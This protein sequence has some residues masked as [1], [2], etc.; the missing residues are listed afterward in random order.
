[1][2]RPLSIRRSHDRLRSLPDD[3][4]KNPTQLKAAILA[5]LAIIADVDSGSGHR[6]DPLIVKV[7]T[8]W[9]GYTRA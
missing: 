3:H 7:C 4:I 8:S 2:S 5:M 6:V 9:P 1:M